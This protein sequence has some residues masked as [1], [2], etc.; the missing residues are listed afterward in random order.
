M[1]LAKTWIISASAAIKDK[2]FILVFRFMLWFAN[3]GC[4]DCHKWWRFSHMATNRLSLCLCHG[5]CGHVPCLQ[6]HV[7]RY[8]A[9]RHCSTWEF[10]EV[11]S[12]IQNDAR[13]D[14][15]YRVAKMHVKWIAFVAMHYKI[16]ETQ[17]EQICPPSQCVS[18]C[19][20]QC[21][22][23]EPQQQQQQ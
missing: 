22:R 17:W 23:I 10:G 14:S 7:V 9:R 20:S 15:M 21:R 18:S 2:H 4:H 12:I 13:S 8:K 11:I 6:T 5:G 16:P 19:F 1:P 3:N